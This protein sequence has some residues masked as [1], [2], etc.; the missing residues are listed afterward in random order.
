ML[1]ELYP[2][3]HKTKWVRTWVRVDATILPL[4]EILWK[5]GMKTEYSCSGGEFV[6]NK[7]KNAYILFPSLKDSRRFADL[8]VSKGIEIKISRR[9]DICGGGESVEWRAEMTSILISLVKEL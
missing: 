6:G 9:E 4:L 5:K 3:P 8:L 7:L 1:N 2:L